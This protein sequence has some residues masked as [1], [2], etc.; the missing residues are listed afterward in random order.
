MKYFSG[1]H[2]HYMKNFIQVSPPSNLKILCETLQMILPMLLSAVNTLSVLC[3]VLVLV[4]W[5]P[6]Y[7]LLLWHI[8]WSVDK[9]I[10]AQL[11]ERFE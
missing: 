5:C 3:V 9:Y 8:I 4:L 11:F 10:Y 6:V 7:I 1:E 2:A